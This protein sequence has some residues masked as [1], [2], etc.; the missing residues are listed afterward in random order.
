MGP[1]GFDQVLEIITALRRVKETGEQYAYNLADQKKAALRESRDLSKYGKSSAKVQIF[2][3]RT[4][5]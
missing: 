4:Q 1:E 5:Q 3:F 2:L